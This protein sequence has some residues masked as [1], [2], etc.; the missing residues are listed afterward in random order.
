MHAPVVSSTSSEVRIVSKELSEP[1]ELSVTDGLHLLDHV[2]NDT[3]GARGRRQRPTVGPVVFSVDTFQEL[4]QFDLGL[5]FA[6]SNLIHRVE[7]RCQKRVLIVASCLAVE[8]DSNDRPIEVF[9]QEALGLEMHDVNLGIELDPVDSVFCWHVEVP[10]Y[11]CPL[12]LCS[13]V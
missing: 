11:G 4:D 12:K 1:L 5:L 2:P 6:N 9:I 7:E 13:I 10:L 8:D 3:F